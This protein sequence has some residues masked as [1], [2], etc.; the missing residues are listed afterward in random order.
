MKTVAIVQARMGS[1]R[2]PGKVLFDLCGKPVIE[3]IVDRIKA[4]G[5]EDVVVATTYMLD[6]LKILKICRNR[7]IECFLGDETN[8]L[9]RYYRCAKKY[10]ADNV[11]RITGDCPFIDPKVIAAT[12]SRFR[13]VGVDFCS[14]RLDPKA[15]PDGMDV[16]IMKFRVLEDAHK[17]ATEPYEKEHV[18]PWIF[19]IGLYNCVNTPS[20][21]VYDEKIHLSMDTKKDYEMVKEIYEALYPVNP[22]FGLDEIM[23]YIGYLSVKVTKE[24]QGG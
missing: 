1:T 17:N 12:V 15:Y 2:L 5:I 21:R 18:T 7:D 10:G 23:D 11:I 9:N 13:D 20:G 3:H 16:E 19:N 4:A 14:A 22:F 8:V 6:D 24:R